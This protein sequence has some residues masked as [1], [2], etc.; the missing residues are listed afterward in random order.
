MRR[1]DTLSRLRLRGLLVG[2]FTMSK[3]EKHEVAVWRSGGLTHKHLEKR[4]ISQTANWRP[5]S[6]VAA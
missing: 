1:S 3:R 5:D 4:G 2:R 6:K